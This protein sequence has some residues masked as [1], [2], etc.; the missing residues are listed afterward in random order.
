MRLD[1]YL[2]EKGLCRSRERAKS[3]IKS[4]LVKVN[5]K[6]A[7]KPSAEVSEGD[8]VE[9]SEG[10]QSYVGRGHVKLAAAFESFD[11][12]VRGKVC[13]DIGASSG[14]FTQ[15]LLEQGAGKVYAVDVGHGQLAQELI[16]DERVVNCEGVNARELPKELFSEPVEFMSVDL[17][18]ISLR[19]VMPALCSCLEEGGEMAVLI[20]P[21]FEA[22]R[23]A[24]NK[25]G[26]VRGRKDHERALGE[27]FDCFS[28]CGLAVRGAAFSPIAGGD[29]NI[30]YLAHLTKG[31]EGKVPDVRSLVSAAFLNFKHNN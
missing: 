25:N 12:D 3:L 13:A 20:K 6:T 29:G 16:E 23:A 27:V 28:A 30:E 22:G 5:G 19:L 1:I 26:I 7:E 10:A 15:C 24:L 31:G 21:Q 11:L 8:T 14:G 18:F 17:S 4:S 9:I 2:A